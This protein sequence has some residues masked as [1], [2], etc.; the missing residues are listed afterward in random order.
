M[1]FDDYRSSELIFMIT[2]WSLVYDVYY[3]V[4]FLAMVIFFYGHPGKQNVPT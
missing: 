2:M 1:C 4:Q 3:A